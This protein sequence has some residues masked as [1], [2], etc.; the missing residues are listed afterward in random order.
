VPELASRRHI[1]VI[2]PVV[3]KAL[4]E[5]GVALSDLDG[6]AVTYGPGLVGLLAHRLLDGQGTGLGPRSA[7]RRCESSRGT[8]IRGIPS[9]R[10]RPEFPFLALVVS[11]GH[12]A[13][14]HGARPH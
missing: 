13:L 12:T 11:G 7:S 8:R 14:Y 3:E 9:P 10:I 2:V 6:I 1:E 4:T 5:A